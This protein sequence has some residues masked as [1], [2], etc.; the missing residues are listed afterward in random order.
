MAILMEEGNEYEVRVKRVPQ[1]TYF[2]EYVKIGDREQVES[3]RCDRYI[4]AEPGQQYEIEINIRK[5]FHWGE[6]QRVRARLFLPGFEQR[7][8][9]KSFNREE[10]GSEI[11]YEGASLTIDCINGFQYPQLVGAPFTF[12]E[13]EIGMFHQT[14]SPAAGALS[15]Y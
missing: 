12:R 1:G 10:F 9:S 3:T 6:Y 2:K 13:M 4:V 11:K 15:M 8:A 5:G 14:S 7:V